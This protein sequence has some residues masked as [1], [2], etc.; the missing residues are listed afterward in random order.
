MKYQNPYP[1]NI[2]ITKAKRSW[3]KKR[4]GPRLR[5]F[6]LIILL[7]VG[8]LFVADKL[9]P[10]GITGIL[11]SSSAHA[12]GNN[13][14]SITQSSASEN[15]ATS[16][17]SAGTEIN[18]SDTTAASDPISPQPLD[19]STLETDINSYIGGFQGQYGVTLADISAGGGFSIN[20]GDTYVAASTFKIPLNLYLFNKFKAGSISPDAGMEYLQNDY[21]GGTGKVQYAKVG[22]RYKIRTLSK[23]SI[24][25]SDNV[26][27]N[28]LLRLLGRKNTKDFMR[29]LGGIVVDDANNTS[30]PDDMA[31][32][33]KALYDFCND[34]PELGSELMGYF[35]NTIFSD[36]LPKLLPEGTIIAHKIGNM[37]S[38]VH[39]VGI[40]Y[41]DRTYILAV[42][43]KNVSEEEAYDVIANISKKVFDFM[44][45]N[46]TK[47]THQEEYLQDQ[48]VF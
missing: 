18:N 2:R 22:T 6:V 14:S 48:D 25:Y 5:F 3:R 15:D 46:G 43:S 7:T 19:F 10:G 26:A 31:I 44:Q 30:C 37:T 21:E 45:S 9:I 13:E 1:Y 8:I 12:D 40:I 20:G 32:Y 36:R 33:L 41:A 11:G 27:T 42:M 29:S 4:K 16:S 35:E 23:Y 28:M 47:G 39:D 24:I 34:N 17:I 38:A